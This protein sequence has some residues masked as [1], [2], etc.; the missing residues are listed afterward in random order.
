MS[1]LR[2]GGLNLH[3]PRNFQRIQQQVHLPGVKSKEETSNPAFQLN[4]SQLLVA[5]ELRFVVHLLQNE[6]TSEIFF[7]LYPRTSFDSRTKT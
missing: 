2:V 5:Q 4:L 7:I 1:L 3:D 6:I